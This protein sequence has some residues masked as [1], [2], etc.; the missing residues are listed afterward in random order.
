MED[1]RMSPSL[2]CKSKIIIL[3]TDYE[4]NSITSRDSDAILLNFSI[5]IQSILPSSGVNIR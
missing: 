3:V 1:V 5:F 4:I 2:F